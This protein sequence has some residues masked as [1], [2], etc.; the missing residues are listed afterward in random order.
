MPLD[1]S[2]CFLGIEGVQT[3]IAGLL[4]EDSRNKFEPIVLVCNQIDLRERVK[5]F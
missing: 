1:I 4:R 3:K 2:G 5:I